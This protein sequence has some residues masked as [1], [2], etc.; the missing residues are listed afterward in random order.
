MSQ[1]SVTK[2]LFDA[3]AGVTITSHCG[4]TRANGL[5][6]NFTQSAW[7]AADSIPPGDVRE[8]SFKLL[9]WHWRTADMKSAA[10]VPLMMDC[11]LLE[12]S[13]HD[14]FDPPPFFDDDVDGDVHT[15]GQRSEM[16]YFFVNRHPNYRTDVLVGDLSVSK[17]ALKAVHSLKWGRNWDTCNIWSLC[18]CL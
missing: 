10:R 4:F 2:A 6:Y 17:V 5:I 1:W 16:K 11:F 18:R 9:R 3:A 15:G 13:S 12:A 8:L 14:E 7:D